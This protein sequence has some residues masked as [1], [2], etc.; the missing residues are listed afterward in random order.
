[1]DPTDDNKL[2]LRMLDRNHLDSAFNFLPFEK[3]IYSFQSGFIGGELLIC[4]LRKQTGV[5]LYF[6]AH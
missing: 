1:M 5:L 4:Y 2:L 6:C 3:L